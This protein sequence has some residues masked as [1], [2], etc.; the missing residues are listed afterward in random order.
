MTTTVGLF[1]DKDMLI[2]KRHL[3]NTFLSRIGPPRSNN[4]LFIVIPEKD[5]IELERIKKGDKR[6]EFINKPEFGIIYSIW[7]TYSMTTKEIFID[8]CNQRFVLQ[9]IDAVRLHFEDDFYIVSEYNKELLKDGFASPKACKENSICIYKKNNSEL[10]EPEMTS[11]EMEY[12][13]S[14]K[15]SEICSMNIQL[16][17]KAVTFLQ[18]ITR[19]GVKGGDDG[20]LQREIFGSL[21]I[22]TNKKGD[23]G[24]IIHVLGVDMPSLQFGEKE[25]VSSVNP[26]LY[27]FHSHPYQAYIRNNTT[28]GFPS[29][30][31]YVSTYIMYTIGM[32]VHFVA[33][34]EGL[35]VVSVN[36]KSSILEKKTNEIEQ[37]IKKN[38]KIDKKSVTDLSQYL[39]TVND[40]GLFNVKLLNWENATNSFSVQ[41]NKQN[42]TCNIR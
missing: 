18:H 39:K 37:F 5:L 9:F 40:I 31:D 32:I 19:A 38:F 15:E 21:S 27:T 6:L 35:Y 2:S 3:I 28:M 12:I 7:T 14:Q 24:K 41:F 8:G 11:R 26:N 10:S 20:H 36:P 34:I 33:A 30:A 17:K 22:T 1:F 25:V 29:S 16:D 42:K 4:I 13:Q 23:D